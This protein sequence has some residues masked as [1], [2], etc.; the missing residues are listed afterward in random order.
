M[1]FSENDIFTV[2]GN[3]QFLRF[4]LEIFHYQKENNPVYSQYVSLL[5]G[6]DYTPQSLQEIPFLPIS[7]FK[8][9]RV[10]TGLF[11][12]EL[13]FSSSGTTGTT[14]STH[15]VKSATIYHQSFVRGFERFFGHPSGFCFLGLLPSYLERDGS[16]LL[17]MVDQLMTISSHPSNGFY[18]NNHKQLAEVIKQLESKNQP[19]ILFG[20]TFGLLDFFETHPIKLK[21]VKIIETGGMKGRRKELTRQ[22]VHQFLSEQTGSQNIYSEYGMTE[23]LS[24]AYSLK[25]GLFECPNWMRVMTRKTNDPL[26]IESHGKTGGINVIDLA[27]LHSCSFIATQDLGKTNKNGQFE[28]LGRFDNSDLRGCNLMAI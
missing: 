15:Y 14:T 18:L 26:S 2:E 19:T 25:D 23:L 7:F 17:Y 13:S 16:S 8:T 3:K 6:K 5:L 4:S 9:H 28:I 20:V 12:H 1:V 22:E 11:D 27:N 10:K 21:N 24:Q